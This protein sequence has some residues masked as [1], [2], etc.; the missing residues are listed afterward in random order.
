MGGGDFLMLLLHKA[1]LKEEDTRFYM[2]EI[3]NGIDA[4]HKL[5]F[6]HR[7]VKVAPYRVC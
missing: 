4:C 3:I 5:G 2:A 1:P 6:M 7:D